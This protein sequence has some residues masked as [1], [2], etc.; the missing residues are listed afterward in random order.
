MRP[1]ISVHHQ[2]SVLESLWRGAATSDGGAGLWRRLAALYGER[3]GTDAPTLCRAVQLTLPSHAAVV[4]FAAHCVD[5]HFTRLA[6]LP[7]ASQVMAALAAATA[8]QVKSSTRLAPLVGALEH[9]HGKRA[10]PSS[11]TAAAST[12]S[13]ELLS[14]G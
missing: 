4:A 3:L 5:A 12:Y 1:E 6:L 9:V 11:Q 7:E 2:V 13:I 8:A 14:I 10:L